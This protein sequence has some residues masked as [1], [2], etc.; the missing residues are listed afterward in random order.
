[1]KLSIPASIFTTVD[2][3]HGV[4]SKDLLT[5]LK[6]YTAEGVRYQRPYHFGVQID[7]LGH[8][9]SSERLASGAVS[10][11]DGLAEGIT[12]TK[13]YLHHHGDDE[14][15]AWYTTH[16]VFN[17]APTGNYN[18]RKIDATIDINGCMVHLRG[19]VN[20]EKGILF[21]EASTSDPT[22]T[23]LCFDLI[24]NTAPTS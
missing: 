12:I 6:V 19:V 24:A 1:M 7:L 20:V 23:P 4:A 10:P 2:P 5:P 3:L 15:I 17:K 21:V 16:L 9:L 14:R 22:I 11:S 8:A 18:D 13:I